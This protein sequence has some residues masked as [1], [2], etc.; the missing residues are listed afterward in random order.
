MALGEAVAARVADTESALIE[1]WTAE[2]AGVAERAVALANDEQ[3]AATAFCLR[4]ERL[5][6]PTPPSPRLRAAAAGRADVEYVGPLPIYS[7][8]AD[9]SAGPGARAAV[10]LGVVSQQSTFVGT[11]ADTPPHEGRPESR[12]D[13]EECRMRQRAPCQIRRC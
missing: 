11:G 6:A 10:P 7:F 8:L 2:L 9:L 3:V 12:L 13:K 4:L 1:E 5:A